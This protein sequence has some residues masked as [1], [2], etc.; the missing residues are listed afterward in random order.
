[1]ID[2]EKKLP[3]DLAISEGVRELALY[4]SVCQANGLVPIGKGSSTNH[5]ATSGGRGTKKVREKTTSAIRK[6]AT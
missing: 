4:A 2:K 5:V 3:S 6:V 1:M